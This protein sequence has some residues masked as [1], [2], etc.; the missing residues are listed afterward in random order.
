MAPAKW[1][2]WQ[3]RLEAGAISSKAVADTI[4]QALI[5]LD[6]DGFHGMYT[7]ASVPNRYKMLFCC[8]QNGN[9]TEM[10]HL[11]LM[12]TEGIFKAPTLENGGILLASMRHCASIVLGQDMAIGYI[13]PQNESSVA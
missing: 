2:K 4:I 8:Y 5:K 1:M 3:R 9:L 13:S 10:E 11:Y 7:L 6:Y 12:A